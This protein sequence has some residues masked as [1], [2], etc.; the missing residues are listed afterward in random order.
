[1]R[2]D[3]YLCEALDITRAWAKKVVKSGD[4]LID[5]TPCKNP[6]MHVP[7]TA[8]VQYKEQTLSLIGTRYIMMN[9]PED[10][11]CSNASNELYPS[12]LSFLDV[13]KVERLHIAGRLDAD[14]TGLILITDDGQWSHRIAS[15]KH[16]CEKVYLAELVNEMSEQQQQQAISQFADGIMLNGEEKPTQA[17][18][19]NF[20]ANDY[21]ELAITEG[22]YHQVKRM[23]AAIGNKVTFLHRCQIGDLELDESLEPGEWRYLTDEEV[24]LF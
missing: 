18:K 8:V 13:E 23:F 4:V 6:A 15:P 24:A 14:T 19:L 5:G 9:K 7:D 11:I 21:A 12:V 3:K 17:A 2:L 20:L 16:V 1:M 10:T 22:R